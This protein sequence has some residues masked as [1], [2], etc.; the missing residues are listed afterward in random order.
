MEII[1]HKNKMKSS[2]NFKAAGWF[3][4]DLHRLDGFITDDKGNKLRFL[5]GKWTDYLKTVP[6]EDYEEY[7]KSNASNFRVPD[8]PSAS[9][10]SAQERIFSKMNSLGG[11]VKGGSLDGPDLPDS[12]TSPEGDIPKSD[13]SNSLDFPNSRLLWVLLPRPEF[14]PQY[15]HFTAFAMSL[16]QRTLELEQVIPKTDS[17]L[18]P[19]VRKLEEGDLGE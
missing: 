4:R 9:P 10:I 6:V 13:S 17:R 19:D 5:Y 18:R 14:S 8:K 1:N 11:L 7:M 15:Y 16:N 12:E 3:G 2:L